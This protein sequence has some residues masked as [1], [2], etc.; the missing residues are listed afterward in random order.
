[1]PPPSTQEV[2][3]IY[4]LLF[5]SSLRAVQYSRPARF[6]VRNRLRKAFRDASGT[7]TYDAGR[8]ARTL[9]F[10]DGATRVKGLE[11]KILKNLMHIWWEQSKLMNAQV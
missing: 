8:V 2:I 11:H 1:M 4:R 9:E 7:T 6:V 3:S 5:K 10:L